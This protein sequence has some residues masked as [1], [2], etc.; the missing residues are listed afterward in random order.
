MS[1]KG[2]EIRKQRAADKATSDEIKQRDADKTTSAKIA[3]A[4][5][6]MRATEITTIRVKRRKRPP[7]ALVVT[8]EEENTGSARVCD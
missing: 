2:D 4:A 8:T 1:R 5:A 7:V 3:A 6:R